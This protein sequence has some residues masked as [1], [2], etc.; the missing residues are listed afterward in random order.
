MHNARFVREQR[1]H[2]P[3]CTGAPVCLSLTVTYSRLYSHI[4]YSSFSPKYIRDINNEFCQF[5]LLFMAPGHSI[6]IR[7][8]MKQ[9]MNELSVQL[10]KSIVFTLKELHENGLLSKV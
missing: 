3:N 10:L 8:D 7:L 1:R 9:K 2:R 6:K 4:N 5:Q